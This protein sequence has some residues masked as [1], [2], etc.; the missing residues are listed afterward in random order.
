M[1]EA[2]TWT[3]DNLALYDFLAPGGVQAVC[4]AHTGRIVSRF[5]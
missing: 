2:S 4:F 1:L 5:I 3:W